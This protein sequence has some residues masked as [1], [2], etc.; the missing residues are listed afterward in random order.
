M[1]FKILKNYM[2]NIIHIFGT[3]LFPLLFFPYVSRVLGPQY[4]GKYNFAISITAYFLILAEFGTQSYGIKELLKAK[5]ESKIQFKKTLTELIIIGLIMSVIS[6]FIYLVV[7]LNVDILKN[8]KSLYLIVG[9]PILTSFLAV[10]FVFI[11][12]EN[13]RRRTIRLILIKIISLVLIFTMVKKPEDYIIFAIILTIPEICVRFFD[14]LSIRKYLLLKGL[15]FVKHMQ[16]LIF[17]FFYTLS[18]SIY[19]NLDSTML[20]FIKGDTEVGYYA[21][22]VK[23][24]KIMIPI[25]TSLGIVLSANIVNKIK[26]KEMKNVYEDIELYSNF[27]FFLSFPLIC[28]LMLLKKDLILLFV[29][30][31]YIKSIIPMVVMLPII[32]FISMSRFY[33]SQLLLPLDK[34]K[35]IFYISLIGLISNFSLNIIFI[36]KYGILGAAI[37]TVISEFIV[38]NCRLLAVK[39]VFKEYKVFTKKRIIYIFAALFS[40]IFNELLCGIVEFENLFFK[41]FITVLLYGIIYLIILIFFKEYFVTIGINIIK[42]LFGK[43]E[44]FK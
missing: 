3:I 34:E 35:N 33:A 12:M 32:I 5:Y 7:I 4:Y 19:L 24:A 42:K 13:Y 14:V 44:R 15:K 31:M 25:T 22:S 41:I 18:T 40:Y 16:A 28:F 6:F 20:G 9:I 29:G 1:N 39:K 17:I 27:I 38:F 23:I 11:A 30:P 8:E 26:N 2:Y 10:D 37:G 36:P 43:K 21:V